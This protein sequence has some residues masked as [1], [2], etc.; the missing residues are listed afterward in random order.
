GT[1]TGGG[2]AAPGQPANR[3]SPAISSR[4]IGFPKPVPQDV[5]HQPKHLVADAVPEI[6][7]ERLEMIDVDQQDAERL[8]L[9]HRCDLGLAKKLVEGT[10]VWQIR[11]R[12]GLGALF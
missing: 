12:I 9:L 8:A 4:Q 11:E 3:F 7:V 5:R 2:G 10:A 6:I 1:R